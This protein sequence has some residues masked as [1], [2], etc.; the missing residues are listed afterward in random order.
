VSSEVARVVQGR[1]NWQIPPLDVNSMLDFATEQVSFLLGKRH[2]H[3]ERV[4]TVPQRLVVSLSAFC[5]LVPAYCYHV[6][7]RPQT[8]IEDVM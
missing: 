5:Y 3:H 2:K 6:R 4:K 1:D 8:T 7:K